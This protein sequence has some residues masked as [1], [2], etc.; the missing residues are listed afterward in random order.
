MAVDM[1]KARDFV[2]SNGILWERALYAYQFEDGSVE[3]LRQCWACY[4]NPDGGF[5][6]ALEHDIRCPDSHP[7]ALEYLL[8][9]IQF[10]Q[11]PVGNVLD[12]TPRWVEKQRE[13]DGSLKNPPATLDYPHAPWWNAGGQTLPTS[14]VGNLT[15]LGLVTAT[16]AESTRKW[17]QANVTLD[18]IRA[19]EWLFMTYHA[20]DYFMKVA[21]FPDV[22]SYRQ[23]TME[24]ILSLAQKAPDDQ[25]YSF[26]PFAPT[27]DSPLA[28]AAPVGLIDRFLDYLLSTQ[29]DDGGW[30]DQ[31]GLPQWRSPV[32]INNLVTLRRYGRLK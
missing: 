16:L 23:A 12:G 9:T 4:K 22:D 8:G 6:H 3:R 29:A 18:S 1:K 21:D 20:Y 13:A 7:L 14:I 17:V 28:K 11:L 24:T 10:H 5:G 26:F 19:T 32:T 31:H 30:R 25:I 2:Y 27:P 15:A